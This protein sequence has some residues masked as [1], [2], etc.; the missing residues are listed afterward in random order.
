[1]L[2]ILTGKTASG[3]DTIKDILLSKYPLLKRIITTTS[4][5]IRSYEKDGID[6][7]F[8]TEG[9]FKDKIKRGEFLEYV[10]YGGNLYG[11]YKKELTSALDNQNLI[12]KI[13]PSRAGEIRDFIKR[14]YSKEEAKKIVDQIIVIYITASDD[15]ILKRLRKR[16]LSEAEID[17][18]MADD[19]SIWADFKD[20]YEYVIENIPGKLYETVDKIVKIVN[21]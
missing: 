21:L 17:H 20:K 18:R 16:G 12:W 1:M 10:K 8:I 19:V 14:V 15:A 9:E 3:K 4:R 7:H 6:Y 13:D 11:T 5:K 2:I